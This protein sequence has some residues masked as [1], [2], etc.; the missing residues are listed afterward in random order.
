MILIQVM[1]ESYQRKLEF[2]QVSIMY[3]VGLNLYYFMFYYFYFKLKNVKR[4]SSFELVNFQDLVGVD[5]DFFVG[6]FL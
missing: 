3:S 2:C 4:K 6:M 1:G 5:E